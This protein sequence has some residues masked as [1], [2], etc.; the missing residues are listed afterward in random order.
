MRIPRFLLPTAILALLGFGAAPALAQTSALTGRVLDAETGQ[1]ISGAVVEVRLPGTAGVTG[2]VSGGNGQFRLE[3]LRAEAYELIVRMVGY[4]DSREEGVRLLPGE[5]SSME[6]RMVPRAYQLDPLVISASRKA[7]QA[8]DAPA[9]TLVVDRRSLEERPTTSPADHLRSVPGVDLISYGL[10]S[11]NV[12]TRGFNNLFSGALYTLTDYR[13]ASVPSLRVNLLHLESAAEED[14]AGMEVVLGP[15]AA[16]YGPNTAN[17]VLHILTRSPLDDQGT[18]VSVTSGERDVLRGSF[19]TAHGL[20][21]NFGFKLSGQ[22]GRASEWE[23][24]DPVEKIARD[25][26]AADPAGCRATWLSGGIATDEAELRCTRLGTRDFNLERW[27]VDGRADWRPTPEWTAVFSGGMSRSDGIELTGLGA[28]QAVGWS[29]YYY[30]ARASRGRLF[31][32]VYLNGSNAGETYLLQNGASI[33]DRS[34]LLVGQ[35]QHGWAP[36]ERQEFTYGIDYLRTMPRTESTINGANEDADLLTEVGGYI[37]SETALT[38][39]FDLVLAGRLDHHS[40]LD[41]PVFSPRAALVFKPATGHNLR[42]TYNSAF[43]TPSSL[44]MF[45]DIHGGSVPDVALASLGYGMRAQGPA[46]GGI[47][48][49]AD[50]GSLLGMRS[51]FNPAGGG[52][53]MPADPSVL[54]ALAVGTMRGQGHIDD[55]TA[56]DLLALDAT[57]L[58]INALDPNTRQLSALENA[59]I[60]DVAPVTESRQTTFEVGYKGLLADQRVLFAADAWYTEKS[61]FISPLLAQTPFLLLEGQSTV[62]MLVPFFMGRG[63]SQEQA[64]AMAVQWVQGDPDQ[65]GDGLAE[66]PLAVASSPD[67]NAVGADMLVS[68]RNFGRVS[69]WGADLAATILLG[70]RWSV[71]LSGSYVSD[72]HFRI[73]LDGTEQV[74]AL[75]APSVKGSTSIAFRDTGAGFNAEARVRYHNAFPANSAGYVGLA[76]VGEA[77]TPACVDDAVLADLTLGYRLPWARGASAQLAVQN[78]FDTAYRSF[79]RVPAMGRLALLRLTYEF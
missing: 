57:G 4:E 47:D 14:L 34:R 40:E 42:V 31:G 28:A 67:V 11:A 56:A 78:L 44:T 49:V 3:G 68:Y 9:T 10:Q 52:Q 33:T 55:A 74:V 48:L 32:Q 70:D 39:K 63:L 45:L 75:N 71:G 26:A 54:W 27:T 59:G 8:L 51:P 46:A 17:G 50:D 12:V 15:G 73:P 13:I 77:G 64:T 29:K 61:D 65:L 21:E 66:I 60:G 24:A 43:E 6:I 25:G 23:F 16:L 58:G 36:G 22:Y 2:S 41:D 53:L 5:A 18:R 69:L 7:E 35:L 19:R 30:Q 1:A 79:V 72:D 20:G 38:Q 62:Q 76:C 37:Q